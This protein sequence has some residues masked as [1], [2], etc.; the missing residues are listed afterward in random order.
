[1]SAVYRILFFK[2]KVLYFSSINTLATMKSIFIT[3]IFSSLLFSSNAQKVFSTD[4]K[5]D[6]D[7]KVFVADSKYDADLIVYKCSSKYD[8]DGNKGLWFFADSKY[9]ADKKVFFVSSKYDADL[10][11]YFSDS[12]YDAE[13]KDSGKKHVMY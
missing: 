3:L 1:M 9:D 7:V 13:W 5:Y 8:A 10:I 2:E 12:K 6:A 4:S 11:I